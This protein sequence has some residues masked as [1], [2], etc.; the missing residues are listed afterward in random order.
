MDYKRLISH[1]VWFVWFT[2]CRGYSAWSARNHSNTAEGDSQLV[3][4]SSYL[5]RTGR[6]QAF[7]SGLSSVISMP[8]MAMNLQLSISRDS[9]S[10]GNLARIR[11]YW[12]SVFQQKRPYGIVSG[13]KNWKQRRTEFFSGTSTVFPKTLILTRCSYGRNGSGLCLLRDPG[14]RPI[15]TCRP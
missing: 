6:R 15:S 10:S 2:N 12:Q 4:G 7:N 3:D 14:L 13:L 8:A 1:H 11:Q 9:S 5:R